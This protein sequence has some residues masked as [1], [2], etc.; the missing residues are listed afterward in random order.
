[1]AE[2]EH[3]RSFFRFRDP[4]QQRIYEELRELVGPGPAAFFRDACWLMENPHELA[5]TALLVGHLLREIESAL[6][7]VLK[8]IALDGA[9]GSF[10][11]L[12]KN[13]Q[14]RRIIESFGL[15]QDSPEAQAWSALAK[16]LHTLAHRRAL[17]SPR[18]PDEMWDLWEQAQ[19]LLDVL[20]KGIRQQFLRWLPLLDQLLAK[21][22][23]TKEDIKRLRN[24]IHYNTVIHSSFLD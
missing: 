7:S 22:Q 5:S 19:L 3:T 23:P 12:P 8:P 20:V 11:G 4:G 18:S 10:E 17:D 2:A 24:E 6:R 1:M 9:E 15:A 21:P 14:I 16:R 13:E